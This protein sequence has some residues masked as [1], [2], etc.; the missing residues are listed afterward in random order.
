MDAYCNHSNLLASQ[1][2]FF[3]GPGQGHP[4]GPDDTVEGLGLED[5][6][7]IDVIVPRPASAAPPAAAAAPS[8][9][10]S[11]GEAAA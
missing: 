9:T 2:R 6:G 1:V 7:L 4:I 3:L 10:R 11:A 5:Q 8:D